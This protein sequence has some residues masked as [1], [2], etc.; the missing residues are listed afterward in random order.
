MTQVARAAEKKSAL[1]LRARMLQAIRAFFFS[2]GY[3]EVETPL[4]IPVP[5]PEAH[6]DAIP[7]GDWFLQ[8]SPEICMKRLLAMGYERIFQISKCFR[9]RE[10]GMLHLPEFTMLEWYRKDSDYTQLMEESEDLLTFVAAKLGF[11]D[12]LPFRGDTILLKRPWLRITVHEAFA[13]YSDISVEEALAREIFDEIMVSSIEPHLGRN[14]PAILYD[15]PV[16]LGALARAKEGEPTVAERFELY[17]G[18]LEIANAFSELTDEQEQ[19]RRFAHENSRRI[20]YGKAAYRPAEVFLQSLSKIKSAA[21]IALG[22]DRLAMVFTQAETIDD[23]VTFTPE[24]L[25]IIPGI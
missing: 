9:S 22:I 16:S 24:E 12:A 4:R 23:V 2:H 19:R 14:R 11:G 20:S 5:L 1:W 18:G 6:I 13:L 15:Y 3:L 25:Q 21:G 10:R 8:T 17:L 7:T